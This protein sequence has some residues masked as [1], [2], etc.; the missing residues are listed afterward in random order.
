[1]M[2]WVM[3][4]PETAPAF[5]L[6]RAGYDVWMGNNR[7]NRFSNTHATL[8]NKDQEYWDYYQEDMGLHDTP[9][10]ILFIKEKTGKE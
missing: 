10:L 4:T 3:N 8:S 6:A 9:S 7:G 1:M 5:V 2:E